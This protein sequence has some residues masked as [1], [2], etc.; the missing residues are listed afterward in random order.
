MEIK[1]MNFDEL[2]TR[3]SEL[4]EE[5]KTADMER[6]DGI[7]AELDAIEER[8]K[9]L[10]TEAEER[11]KV[12]EEVINAPA[13]TPIIEE[14]TQTKMTSKEIRST[15][16]YIDAY[17]EYCKRN[18]DLDRMDAEKRALLT[19]NATEN[20]TIAVPVYVED[21][22]STAWEN[23]EI[24]RRVRRTFFPGNVKVGVEVSSDG[25][26]IHEEGDNPITEENLVIDYVDLIPEYI[27][28][29]VKVSHTAMALKGTAFLDYLYDEIEYQLVKKASSEVVSKIIASSFTATVTGGLT[30]AKLIEAEG[31]L[32]GEARDLVLITTRANAST[33]KASALAGSYAYDPFDGMTVL[34]TDATSL[35]TSLG[36]V[37]DLS[38]VQ[39]NFPEGAEPRFIFDEYTEAPANI[40]RI[41]GRLLVAIEVIAT[42][43]TVKITA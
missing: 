36:V 21:R 27:K 10:K 5:L 20:G 1:E 13:P 35:G 38:G 40:V 7:N 32:G 31:K 25:A 29:M 15:N 26:Q 42:G 11:A 6:L 12:V 19:E 9:E 4:A 23:D 28:K 30:T 17:V 43:K 18:Y 8:K 34:Y 16:E 37:A 33:L 2:Q 3:K 14:R 24:M 39:A 22:I 41:V